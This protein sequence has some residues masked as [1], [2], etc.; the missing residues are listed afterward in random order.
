MQLGLT[1]DIDPI[2]YVLI[3]DEHG[4]D[5]VHGSP[6]FGIEITL[7]RNYRRE[8]EMRYLGRLTRRCGPS[9]II[10]SK[11]PLAMSRDTDHYSFTSQM[12]IARDA[13]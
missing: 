7:W 4:S 10:E 8:D 3:V 1:Y 13:M 12:P 9:G 11:H 6:H 2:P 5:K